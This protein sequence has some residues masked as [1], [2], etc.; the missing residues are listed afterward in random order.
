[1]KCG[2]LPLCY[3]AMML[4]EIAYSEYTGGAPDDVA[5]I[6]QAF[7]S[8]AKVRHFCLLAHWRFCGISDLLYIMMS[9]MIHHCIQYWL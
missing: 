6:Q 8:N 9:G 7:S 3:E 1:M 5:H 2:L 4:G